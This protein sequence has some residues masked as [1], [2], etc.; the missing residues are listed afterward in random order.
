MARATRVSRATP[1]VLGNIAAAR[2]RQQGSRGETGAGTGGRSRAGRRLPAG[3]MSAKVVRTAPA[4]A[5]ASAVPEERSIETA[6]ASPA[7]PSASRTDAMSS[8]WRKAEGGGAFS[9][10]RRCSLLAP[11]AVAAAS[12]S[13][14]AVA[15]AAR[16]LLLRRS[17]RGVLGPLYQLFGLD[18]PAVLVF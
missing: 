2:T 5:S 15:A 8:A 11:F 13:A 6:A 12:A 18:P 4:A 10:R 9:A 17:R 14:A 16:S 1:S 3:A 7:T